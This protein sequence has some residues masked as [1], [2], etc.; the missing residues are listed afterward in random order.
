MKKLSNEQTV[1]A[2]NTQIMWTVT[3]AMSIL[4]RRDT[5]VSWSFLSVN[6]PHYPWIGYT[7]AL[8]ADSVPFPC[9]HVK[10]SEDVNF[11]NLFENYYFIKTSSQ[12]KK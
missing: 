10:F 12:K 8:N 1:L 9:F 3:H 2:I 7:Q 11:S 5:D 4:D 6:F